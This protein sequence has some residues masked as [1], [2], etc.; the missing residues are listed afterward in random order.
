MKRNYKW[1]NVGVAEKQSYTCGYCDAFVGPS[2]S[3]VGHDQM[4]GVRAHIFI[5][6]NCS[7]PTLIS[8]E[9]GQVPSPMF[10]SS[11]TSITDPAILNLYNEARNCFGAMAYTGCV[12]VARKILMNLAVQHGAKENL[13]FIEYINYLSDKNWIP[14]N[15]KSWVDQIRQKGNEANHEI[16]MIE[17]VDAERV[18]KFLE[19]LLKFM[20]DFSTP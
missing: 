10:K 3:Y 2:Q 13:K 1:H 15:G 16:I 19:M 5:C 9:R 20:Y 12:M 7:F 17:R 6:S 4:T 8:A 11:V 18:L 14:P